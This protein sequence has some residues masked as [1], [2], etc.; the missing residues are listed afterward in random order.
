MRREAAEGQGQAEGSVE[1]LHRGNRI[2]VGYGHR[3][4]MFPSKW[5]LMAFGCMTHTYRSPMRTVNV[6]KNIA[7]LFSKEVC[8]CEFIMSLV[9]PGWYSELY[10]VAARGRSR[11]GE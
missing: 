8:F 9:S 2:D 7:V 3:E 10:T 6:L 4:D 1:G 11:K 5:G